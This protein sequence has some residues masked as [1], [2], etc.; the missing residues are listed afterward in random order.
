[1]RTLAV[2]CLKAP[3]E[4]QETYLLVKSMEYLQQIIGDLWLLV[5]IQNI[6]KQ[7]SWYVDINIVFKHK[8]RCRN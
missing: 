3:K 2:L 5:T 4:G 7:I 8:Y 1:M 6:Q